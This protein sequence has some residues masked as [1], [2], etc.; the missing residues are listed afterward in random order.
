M[1]QLPKPSSTEI[2]LYQSRQKDV[3]VE[4]RLMEETVWLTQAQMAL[5]F[6]KN[7][8]TVNE[9]IKN[10]FKERELS[11][12]SVIR[13]F[14]ITAKDGKQYDT[15][16]Y[17]LDVIISV[18]YRV[19]SQEG[20]RFRVWATSVLRDHIL[21]GFT[22]NQKRLE[23]KRGKE[24]RELE[25]AIAL[26]QTTVAQ[27]Y[28]NRDEA[29]GLVQVITDYADSWLLLHQYD[30]GTL[31]GERLTKR[32]RYVLVAGQAYQAIEELAQSLRAR[33]EATSFFG[34]ERERGSLAGILGNIEQS[35]SG[36][37][38]YP[39]IEEKAAHLLYFIIK[40]HPFVDGNKRIGSFL[41]ILYLARNRHL[42]NANG[43]KKIND[44]ALVALALLV[45][46]SKPAQKDV[47]IKLI[48]NLLKKK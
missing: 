27:N 39:S 22:I 10:T 17:N 24:L 8:R 21:K 11:Q 26:L 20:T 37:V 33:K 48:L 7:I 29:V 28:L 18:G 34:S 32:T 30:Q 12:S 5:L 15:N 46:E 3:S 47:I 6:N 44:N 42:F 43:E 1:K 4:A 23:E 41:F 13:K 35:F 40:D 45:A 38:L 14:R 31:S 2:I 19:K 16:F 25:Q 9:H 36:R